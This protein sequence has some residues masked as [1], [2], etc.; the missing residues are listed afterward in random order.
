M[1]NQSERKRQ[2]TLILA[3]A[4]PRR[5]EL[6]ARIEPSFQVIPVDVEE[7]SS[8]KIPEQIVVDIA[9]LKVDAV[10]QAGHAGV[11][12]GADTAVVLEGC[13]LGKPKDEA[14]AVRM[15]QALSGRV[16]SVLTGIWLLDTATKKTSSGCANTQVQFKR[17]DAE[18]IQRYLQVADY[19]DK[20]GAY[21]IQ[22]HD[23]AFV[24]RLEGDY[25]N[26]MGLPVAYAAE[27]LRRVGYQP[28]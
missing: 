27:L 9:R 13:V 8:S 28:G 14:D 4:S 3:S 7:T 6:L 19:A 5:R 20:A 24:E 10:A 21:A 2:S 17:L 11:I 25:Y 12:L 15:L 16:H 18:T 23:A 22:A 1:Q 26:V